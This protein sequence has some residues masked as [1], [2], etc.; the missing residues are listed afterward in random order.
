[1][2]TSELYFITIEVEIN[3]PGNIAYALNHAVTI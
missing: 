2:Q 3:S 1:L